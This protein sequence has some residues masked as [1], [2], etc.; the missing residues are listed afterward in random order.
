[1]MASE[2]ESE[3]EDELLSLAAYLENQDSDEED[4]FGGLASA[5]NG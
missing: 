1:M 3:E 4:L 5:L 2:R